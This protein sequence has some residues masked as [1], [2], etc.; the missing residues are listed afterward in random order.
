MTNATAFGNASLRAAQQHSA[1][2]SQVLA[3]ERAKTQARIQDARAAREG[4][5]AQLTLARSREVDAAL[6]RA[7]T[8]ADTQLGRAIAQQIQLQH[9]YEDQIKQTSRAVEQQRAR[10]ESAQKSWDGYKNTLRNWAIGAGIV[11]GLLSGMTRGA[12]ALEQRFQ[13]AQRT[14]SAAAGGPA[15][16]AQ[17]MRFIRE[18]AD[19][20]G[21][22]LRDTM[23]TYASWLASVRGTPIAGEQ[24]RKIY[25]SV[26]EA[27]TVMGRSS[28]EGQRAFLALSQM[29]SKGCHAKGTLIRLWNGECRKVEEVEVGD[30]LMGPDGLP[31]AVLVLARGR[32]EMFRVLPSK[33][34]P[35]VVN[36]NHILR[37]YDRKRRRQR[38]IKVHEYLALPEDER[39]AQRL[40]HDVYGEVEFSAES[41]GVDDFYGFMISGD[42]LYRDGQG[43]VHHNTVSMEELRQQLGEAIPGVMQL[44]ADSMGMTTARFTELVG[45]GQILASD[46]LPKLAAKMSETFGGQVASMVDAFPARLARFQNAM[47]DLRRSFAQGFL[48]GFLQGLGELQ[49]ALTSGQIER[50]ARNIGETIGS[51]FRT[52]AQAAAFLI[53]H[54]DGIKALLVGIVIVKTATT[55]LGIATALKTLA[56]AGEAAKISI[57]GMN[58]AFLASPLGWVVVG[59]AAVAGGLVYLTSK[60]DDGSPALSQFDT[61]LMQ[62]RDVLLMVKATTVELAQAQAALSRQNLETL[63]AERDKLAKQS[64]QLRKDIEAA[65]AANAATSARIGSTWR[66]SRERVKVDGSLSQFAPDVAG[67]FASTA[68]AREALQSVQNAL[69]VLVVRTEQAS[70]KANEF[71]ANL[72]EIEKTGKSG[73]SGV[74]DMSKAQTNL[75]ERLADVLAKAKA[76]AEAAEGL[77]AA[78]LSG[79]AAE[80]EHEVA[81]AKLNAA[82][83][84]QELL[85][86]ALK[87][88]VPIPEGFLA[89]LLEFVEREV[90]AGQVTA[91]LKERLDALRDSFDRL[92]SPMR[93]VRS[94]LDGLA[95]AESFDVSDLRSWGA[96]MADLGFGIEA[97]KDRIGDLASAREALQ[98]GS[99]QALAVD[100][101]LAAATVEL[102]ASQ[103]LYNT[104]L[105][106]TPE[107]WAR[108]GAA[109]RSAGVSAAADVAKAIEAIRTETDLI[110]AGGAAYASYTR[111]LEIHNQALQIQGKLVQMVG[112]SE[113]AYMV[114]RVRAYLD[115][116]KAVEELSAVQ[117]A[118]ARAEE[119]VAPLAS[120]FDQMASHIGSAITEGILTGKIAVK[121]LGEAMKQ[122]LAQAVGDMVGDFIA[123]W[124]RTLAQWLQAWIAK[125]IAAKAAE[126]AANL[127]G[128]AASPGSSATGAVTQGATSAATNAAVGGGTSAAAGGGMSAAMAAGATVAVFAVVYFAVSQWIKTHRKIMGEATLKLTQEG[129]MVVNDVKGSQSRFQLVMDQLLGIGKGMVD[130]I[131]SLGGTMESMSDITMQR[132]GQGKKTNWT[133]WVD[134]VAQSFGKDMEAAAEYAFIQGIKSANIRG[135]GPLVAAA[136]K[137]SMTWDAEQFQDDIA[138]ARRLEV[139]NLPQGAQQ[140]SA[141]L[142]QFN[143]DWA[144]A[145]EL[146][147]RDSASLALALESIGAQLVQSTWSQYNQLTGRQEDPMVEH[148]RKVAAYNMQRTLV[149]AQIKIMQAE[150]LA[151][152]L[153]IQATAYHGRAILEHSAGTAGAAGIMLKAGG[154]YFEGMSDMAAALW[155]QYQELSRLAEGIAPAIDPNDWD[156]DGIENDKDKTPWGGKPGR[157]GGNREQARDSFQERLGELRMAS[158]DEAQQSFARMNQELRTFQEEGKKAKAS[159]ADIAEGSR[160]IVEAWRKETRERMKTLAGAGTD[161]TRQL[162]EGMDFFES[163]R[164]LKPKDTGITRPEIRDAQAAFLARMAR[165]L[166]AAINSFAGIATPL[167]DIGR[168]ADELRTNILALADAAGW[169]ADKIKAALDRVAA[170]QA[171]QSELAVI[172]M[173]EKLFGYLEVSG[174]FEA[175]RIKLAQRKFELE[176]AIVAAQLTLAGVFEQFADIFWAAVDAGY[177]QAGQAAASSISSAGDSFQSSAESAASAIKGA[178]DGLRDFV[179]DLRTDDTLSALSPQ[180]KKDAALASYEDVLAKARAKDPEAMRLLPNVAREAL[181]EFLSFYKGGRDE[182]GAAGYADFFNRVLSE[183]EGLISLAGGWTT[184]PVEQAVWAVHTRM[185]DSIAQ[186]TADAA[187]I[188]GSVEDLRNRLAGALGEAPKTSAETL[189]GLSDMFKTSVQ[190]QIAPDVR[191]IMAHLIPSAPDMGTPFVTV[192]P[193]GNMVPTVDKS[194]S[195]QETVDLLRRVAEALERLEGG[196][197]DLVM[198]AGD[199][200]DNTG[201][202]ADNSNKARSDAARRAA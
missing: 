173:V 184:D 5:A 134:G 165:D 144:R 148:G 26:A 87:A 59:L 126:R 130:F 9:R 104:A 22:V 69:Q 81:T 71:S 160:L 145:V 109:R 198:I 16:A 41:V 128:T 118:Q 21:L 46:L 137:E 27:L 101:A 54:L 58:A 37:T 199:I 17:E 115:A 179:R 4:A 139:Q 183:T 84:V 63:K 174:Q 65:E 64:E 97:L 146:F 127:G 35:F 140:M 189:A 55:L 72:A 167:D 89:Q 153:D 36:K 53:Q 39:K 181:S 44:A 186:G 111:K 162:T 91:V 25:I 163:L 135:L 202:V 108:V 155:A 166:N 34:T 141:S 74:N 124:L 83:G 29:A 159:A 75:A 196:N 50:A 171:V 132:K 129:K 197:G 82:L 136:I 113:A 12:L 107:I 85:R 151:R 116:K 57:L 172:G 187:G 185:S 152:M 20:L 93:D 79:A 188:R 114:R 102:A 195:D 169:S 176:M 96:S 61:N 10:V 28:E 192:P 112:E 182:S 94:T 38:N 32:E 7:Q 99:E 125:L 2:A 92:S 106:A 138:F 66:G 201:I 131:G 56:L 31:R 177:A 77:S 13:G 158:L 19:R 11:I 147:K 45:K 95:G 76:G 15:G 42:H 122:S 191:S 43:F 60:I 178:V 98:D 133:V 48:A 123:R 86:E 3:A 68:K 103:D 156:G 40:L 14:L 18:E 157:G 6:A 168:R 119:L 154:I 190:D 88:K 194:V 149:L 105:T 121:E 47:D 90:R 170:A 8:T 67:S 51:V 164:R 23:G 110:L 175:E 193:P 52:V 143:A 78:T 73:A 70:A 33:G 80:R 49:G 30:L 150:I 120:A 200:R 1:A 24:A 180:A 100:R 142:V 62:H 161:F 117:I